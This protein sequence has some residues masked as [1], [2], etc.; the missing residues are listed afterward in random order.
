MKRILLVVL[1]LALVLVGCSETTKQ[2]AKDVKDDVV[3]DVEKAKDDV[4]S[5]AKDAKDKVES[6]VDKLQ[7]VESVSIG[8]SPAPH[9]EIVEALADEFEAAGIK[10]DIVVM[11]DYVQ[12]NLA[13]EDGDLDMN[14][15]QHQPYLDNF[16]A[17]HGTH[18][19]SIGKVH[20]ESMALYSD[21]YTSIDE[22]PD[23]A[24]IIIPSDVTNGARALIILEDAGLIKLDKPGDLEATVND[25]V[26]NPKNL[27]ITELDA[28]NIARTYM[29]VDGGIINANF[30]VDAGLNPRDDGL[31]VEGDNSPYSNIVAVR[32]GE[33][34]NPVY[35]KVMEVLNS[36][37]AEQIIEERYQGAVTPV[38]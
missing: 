13:L 29:D 12:P 19:V 1:A 9:A 26:D 18:L 31:I 25:I 6:E 14:F 4:K 28:A 5:E 10:M 37:K 3:S 16:N 17:E 32:E 22:L 35:L 24:E 23:G 36:P 21:K 38:F 34:N 27:V 7:G 33:E 30:A 20:V 2:D 11:D 8:V 15:M